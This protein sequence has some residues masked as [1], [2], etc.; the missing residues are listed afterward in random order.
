MRK[1]FFF[2]LGLL[3]AAGVKTINA[4]EIYASLSSDHK[5]MT[6]YYG[7]QK[8]VSDVTE[9]I[10][11]ADFFGEH[12]TTV[13]LDESMQNARPTSLEGWFSGFESMKE[14]KNLN[15]LNT[16]EV[17]N[18][19]MLFNDC[20]GLTSIDISSWDTRKVTDMSQMF[21]YCDNLKSV[22][23]QG[24]STAQV[25][26]MNYMFLESKALTSLDLTGFDT[27]NVE[28][29]H[30]M[31]EGC[32][33]LTTIYCNEDWNTNTNLTSYLSHYNL[34]KDCSK[35]VG[36]N[37]TTYASSKI[38]KNYAR[39]DNGPTSSQPGYFTSE[40]NENEIYAVL[41]S[42]NTTL[43]LYYDKKRPLRGGVTDW[44]VYD[45]ATSTPNHETNNITKIV[46]DPSMEAAR[47]ESTKG[48]FSCFK[49]LTSIEHLEYL[50]TITVTDMSYMFYACTALT[51]LNLSHFYTGNVKNISYMFAE[52]SNLTSLDITGW[53]NLSLKIAEYLFYNCSK[54]STIYCELDLSDLPNQVFDGML[55]YFHDNLFSGCTS[56]VGGKGTK[57]DGVNN[58]AQTYA[59]P[60]NPDNGKP[61]YFSKKDPMV[62]DEVMKSS[63]PE[64]LKFVRNGQLLIL[65][66]GVMYNAHGARVE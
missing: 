16:S 8:D 41:E 4:A 48:W 34:F 51:T 58:I 9:W 62:I 32:S 25:T 47:P 13:I 40:T 42:D 5:T 45:N 14:I 54:L 21:S 22:N 39:P 44:S 64:I 52:C 6:L 18:M 29:V 63:N 7:E 23:L 15:Y 35:L 38:D 33:E 36:G 56:L 30:S 24:V 20:D 27:K 61:G 43:T 50:S 65:R 2:A 60:D 10:V 11:Y 59:R 12:I 66:D 3:M 31:F 57:C 53:T 28:D 55:F 17:T 49:K 26:N 37:G 1:I 46:L 19:S